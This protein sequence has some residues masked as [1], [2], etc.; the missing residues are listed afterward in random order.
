MPYQI[1]TENKFKYF[2]I[3]A[4]KKH[5][6]FFVRMPDVEGSCGLE[7]RT[8]VAG[9]NRIHLAENRNKWRAFVNTVINR[10]VHNIR[11]ILE[12]L[13]S[14]KVLRSVTSLS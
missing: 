5:Y 4:K 11:E 7:K 1:P 3:N 12:Q 8:G 13:A 6:N 10:Q 9:E 2:R 14:E